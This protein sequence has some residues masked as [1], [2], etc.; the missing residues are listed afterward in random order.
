MWKMGQT[1]KNGRK[2]EKGDKLQKT[3]VKYELQHDKRGI[4]SDAKN[5]GPKQ[6]VHPCSLIR[7]FSVRPHILQYT[8]I[9]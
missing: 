7:N 2:C 6:P 8:L 9:L 3:R 1:V 4:M 5:K